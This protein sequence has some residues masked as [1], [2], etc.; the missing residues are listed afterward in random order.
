MSPRALRIALLALALLFP[1]TA[2]ADAQ[3]VIKPSDDVNFRL[4]ILGQFQADT[5]EDPSS[6][7]TSSPR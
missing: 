1:H 2:P 6:W 5:L 7:D 4:G 3:L